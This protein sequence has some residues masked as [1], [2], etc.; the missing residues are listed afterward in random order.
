MTTE[1]LIAELES[2]DF[3]VECNETSEPIEIFF[4]GVNVAYISSDNEVY[5]NSTNENISYESFLDAAKCERERLRKLI[6]SVENVLNS[7]SM[8]ISNILFFDNYDDSW[9]VTDEYRTA[10]RAFEK[11][12]GKNESH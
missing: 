5:Q 12:E 9:S 4:V 7:S 11:L 2:L 1:E 6:D 8:S 10:K 3:R